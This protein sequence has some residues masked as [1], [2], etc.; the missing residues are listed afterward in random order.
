MDKIG[1]K[2]KEAHHL[3][4]NHISPDGRYVLVCT[5]GLKIYQFKKEKRE[6]DNDYGEILFE[7]TGWTLPIG[8]D[9]IEHLELA[10]RVRFEAN[11]VLRILT[12]EGK[13]ILFELLP[14]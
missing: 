14:D 13:D 6:E 12:K 3:L 8:T 1:L 11:N 9:D 7:E 2:L 10:S 5:Q 4:E